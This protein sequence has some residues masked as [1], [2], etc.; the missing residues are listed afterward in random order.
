MEKDASII[1]ECLVNHLKIWEL[2]LCKCVAFGSDGA[3]TMVGSHGGVATKLKKN[4]NP[5]ILSCHCVAHRTNLA[6]LDASKASDCKVIS[7]DVDMILNA[8]ASYFNSSSKRK[9]ALTTLQSVLFDAKKTM[10]RYHKIRWLSRWQAVTT[11]CDSLES[12]LCFF[13]DVKDKKDLGQVKVIFGKLKQFKYIY[14]LYFLADI[15]HSLALLSKIFQNKFV[16]VTTIGSIVRT[17]IAQIRMLFIVEQTDLNA[18]TFNE[19]TGYHVIP[20]YGPLGGHLRKLSSE[21]HGKMYHGFEMDRSRLGDDLEEALKFQHAFAEAVCV[22]LAA[23]FV[24]NDLIS[25]FKILNPTNMPSKQIGL[26]NWGVVELEKLL[27]HYGHDRSQEGSKFPPFVDVM[28]CKREF[29]A[30][31]LQ[32]TTEWGDKTC[33]DLW[34][35]ITWNHSLQTRYPNLL[36]LADLARVQCVSTSTCERAFSVQNLI[37]T[38][39]RNRLG[40]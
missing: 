40:S 21:I 30:F 7:D 20:E 12:V 39:V 10:K 13:R 36:V 14:I 5:F 2:D 31:K 33:G 17:E 28:A 27:A 32:A 1:F 38:R 34:G 9:H 23:R 16:D 11:L 24:D 18:S 35:M 6:S 26:Q 22:G 19:N 29:L 25:C 8:I 4:L 37:K 3:S 15:L